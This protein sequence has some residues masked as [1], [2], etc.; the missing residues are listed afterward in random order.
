MANHGACLLSLRHHKG[1]AENS[2]P[3]RWRNMPRCSL[4]GGHRDYAQFCAHAGDS[5]RARTSI[6]TDINPQWDEK[7]S[8]LVADQSD[9]VWLT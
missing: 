1:K 7:F 2:V 9:L 4:G 3:V 8:I 5:R 6:K